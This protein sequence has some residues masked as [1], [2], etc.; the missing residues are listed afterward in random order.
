MEQLFL[1]R[2]YYVYYNY[3]YCINCR[4]PVLFLLFFLIKIIILIFVKDHLVRE[5]QL[6][7]PI[8]DALDVRNPFD[9]REEL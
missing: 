1:L 8:A 9:H 2:R 7:V 4:I 5:S 6:H 3:E